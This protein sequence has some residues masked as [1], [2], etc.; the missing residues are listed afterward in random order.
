MARYAAHL[1]LSD[2]RSVTAMSSRSACAEH[3][4]WVA[5]V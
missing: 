4:A 3:S 5:W 1:A 2:P